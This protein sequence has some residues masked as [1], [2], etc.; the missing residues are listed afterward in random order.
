MIESP[1]L[2]E[3]LAWRMHKDIQRVLQRRFG[4]LPAEVASKLQSIQEEN[5]LDA[6]LDWAVDCPDLNAFQQRL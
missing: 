1:V 3:L 5:R 2:Q 6:L 4:A